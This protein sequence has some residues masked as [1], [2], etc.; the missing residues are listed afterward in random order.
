MRKDFAR[1]GRWVA[2]AFD[3]RDTML[4]TG[5]ILLAAGLFLVWPP[6]ALIVPGA[7]ISA[8][9]IFADRINGNAREE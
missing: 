9:A 1:L 3:A 5:L 4:A 2:D 6:L 8:V 7:I